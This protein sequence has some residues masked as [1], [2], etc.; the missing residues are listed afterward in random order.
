MNNYEYKYEPSY[1][2]QDLCNY[3][4]I[5][6]LQ[7][8][9]KTYL[10]KKITNKLDFKYGLYILDDDLYKIIEQNNIYFYGWSKSSS[11]NSLSK[12]LSQLRSINPNRNYL[13]LRIDEKGNEFNCLSI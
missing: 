12:Y 9:Y 4:E 11:K 7:R 8:Y 3:L 2:N 13:T 6:P 1:F 10:L 5:S